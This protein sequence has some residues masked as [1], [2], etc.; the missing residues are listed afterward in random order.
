ML[1]VLSRSQYSPF[2]LFYALFPKHEEMIVCTYK[3]FVGPKGG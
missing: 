3:E 2:S 1:Y